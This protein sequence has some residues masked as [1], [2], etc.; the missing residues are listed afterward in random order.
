MASGITGWDWFQLKLLGIKDWAD[1]TI[2]GQAASNVYIA[3]KKLI[4]E[5]PEMKKAMEE[6]R[7]KLEEIKPN[8]R[9]DF[10]EARIERFHRVGGPPANDSSSAPMINED[11]TKWFPKEGQSIIRPKF[12]SIKSTY[13]EIA[14]TVANTPSFFDPGAKPRLFTMGP[15][16]QVD[17]DVKGEKCS[18]T[19][20]N[21][22]L[23]EDKA[24][25]AAAEFD[26]IM[27]IYSMAA[28]TWMGSLATLQVDIIKK[29]II[30]DKDALKVKDNLANAVITAV[31][32]A[33]GAFGVL[34]GMAPPIMIPA[35]FGYTFTMN[36]LKAQMAYA[37]SYCYTGKK[38]SSDELKN[39]L[40]ILFGD[41]D[42]EVS[43]RKVADAAVSSGL[44]TIA[45]E[46]ISKE[47]L[48]KKLGNKFLSIGKSTL[49][50]AAMVK[51]TAKGIAKGIPIVS[52]AIGAVTNTVEAASFGKQ[53][54]RY[55]RPVVETG[56]KPTPT[57]YTVT[58][59]EKMGKST[60]ANPREKIV[61]P[62][63]TK[64]DAL[65][66]PPAHEG[67]VFD[68]WNLNSDGSG[69]TFDAN[70]PVTSSFSVYAQWKEAV[71]T[72]KFF[73]N[74]GA[75]EPNPQTK[76][77]KGIFAVLMGLGSL[78]A[79]PTRS[80]Y[81]FDGWNTKADGSGMPF[82]A[83]S[84]IRE[85]TS[86]YAKWKG[87][88]FT[89][90]FDRNGG[91]SDANP[92]SRVAPNGSTIALP[93][94]PIRP[95]YSFTGWNTQ[96]AGNGN[97]FDQNSRVNSDIKL[98]AQWKEKTYTVNYDTNGGS[99][100]AAKTGV[101]W[102]NTNL[103]PGNPTK[104]NSIFGGWNVSSGGS[105]TNVSN[106]AA[107]SS[108]ASN[109]SVSSITLKAQW[110]VNTP[111][112]P[113]PTPKP[114]TPTPPTANSLDGV[115][116]EV[117]GGHRV[118]TIS[119][120]TGTLG[121]NPHWRNLTST[122]NL[123]WSGQWIAT[124]NS[125]INDRWTLS[126]DGQTMFVGDPRNPGSTFKRKGGGTAPTKPT[127]SSL[128]GVWEE[129]GGGHRVIT[130]SG[131]TGTLGGN[132]HWRNLTSTG[133][134]AWSGQWIAASNSWI[135]DRWTLSPDGQ[136]M[137]VGDPRSPGSTFKRKWTANDPIPAPQPQP[138]P[139]PDYSA[140]QSQIQ[141][142]CKF[143]D[144]S[145]VWNVIEQHSDPNAL[146][147]KLAE[148]LSR[149]KTRDNYNDSFYKKFAGAL[150]GKGSRDEYKEIIQTICKFHD[151][152]GVWV[153]LDKHGYADDLY[154]KLAQSLVGK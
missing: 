77:V 10:A 65:P 88:G 137:F 128:D 43:L 84:P 6:Q 140:Y 48:W 105:G 131:S 121:G 12:V 29:T 135:N 9:F 41:D 19:L 8:I 55:Y 28:D 113:E 73:K 122:G 62:P 107:F 148:T 144:P 123:T 83:A 108:L 115:W 109:D 142:I 141:G 54:K 47:A 75:Y 129:V 37:I 153:V 50:D 120:S 74:D 40:Y 143:H 71:Y 98:H 69:K 97:V 52:I 24:F 99:A 136:T 127:A 36:M 72:V 82:S 76:S 151:P 81:A 11:G 101:K 15:G 21:G 102:G 91:T 100:I 114:P 85:N 110:N 134:L 94:P 16:T 154:R 49:K 67:Y 124:S 51:N 68:S 53:A 13:D 89:V 32:E 104:A 3:P 138:A 130:I 34:T 20:R 42:V 63:A 112:P 58:F 125:W 78:P 106:N 17:F 119:G 30:S 14:F 61:T 96:P 44:Q 5:N 118:I 23:I 126:P 27:G 38:I 117:G 4:D 60:P 86:V 18:F 132:P 64:I 150:S 70:T 35:E 26:E 31:S 146:Y 152:S 57:V 22:K 2:L 103:L 7:R 133:N 149:D 79:P 25:R 59:V 80:G 95:G 145:G 90:T 92:P 87:T 1:G 139:K 45:W 56:N 33:S 111:T 116:E 147:R 39:D 93:S 66:T 46:L